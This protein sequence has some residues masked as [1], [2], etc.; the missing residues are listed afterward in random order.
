MAI[1]LHLYRE[2]ESICEIS[3]EI[4]WPLHLPRILLSAII[5][6]NS[7]DDSYI[8]TI[9]RSD[10]RVEELEWFQREKKTPE[11]ETPQKLPRSNSR[12]FIMVFRFEISQDIYVV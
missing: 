8:E 7:D 6:A 10:T 11:F 2:I 5:A 1:L 4:K 9:S 3:R 12:T